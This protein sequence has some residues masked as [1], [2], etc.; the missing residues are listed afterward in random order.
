MARFAGTVFA[1]TVLL[2]A[3]AFAMPA[4]AA[5][6]HPVSADR[7]LPAPQVNAAYLQTLLDKA[8]Y[9]EFADQLPRAAGLKR[10]QELYFKGTLAY[11]E[12][13]FGEVVDPLVAAVE[14]R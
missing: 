9:I 12:G 1:W 4:Q 14:T 11:R 8:N 6:S 5:P 3:G 7:S 13:H 10:E 2:Y